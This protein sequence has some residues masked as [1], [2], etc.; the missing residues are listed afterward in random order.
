MTVAMPARPPRDQRLDVVR[1]ILQ[2][3][4][5]ARH[6][7]GS[8]IG[9]WVIHSNWGLSDSSELFLYLSGYTLGSVIA[10]KQARDG[11]AAATWDMLRRT[12][13][14]YR[15]HLAVFMLMAAMLAAVDAWWLPGEVVGRRWEAFWFDPWRAI[16]GM[17]TMVYQPELM[18]ILPM[19]VWSMALL[20]AYAALL[21]RVGDWGL[22]VPIGFYAA[23]QA[24]LLSTPSFGFA[25]GVEFDPIAWQVLFMT[26]AWVGRR[27]LL[28]GTTFDPQ[29]WWARYATIAAIAVLLAGLVLRLAWYGFLPLA[30]PFPEA[31]WITG[32]LELA[33]PRLLHMVALAW[34]VARF[35]PHDRA[36]MHHWSLAWLATVGRFSLEVFCLGLFLAWWA[37]VTLELTGHPMVLDIAVTLVGFALLAGFAQWRDRARNVAP[38]R[39]GGGSGAMAAGAR[40]G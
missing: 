14:L 10:L 22:L 37:T 23:V 34:L 4:I 35:V 11:A 7:G 18:G 5:F 38:V 16:P 26:G 40:P 32:K 1:G 9:G 28:L 3:S 24:G 2:L 6:I 33:A 12:L 15:I 20:P 21:G 29:A 17:L 25:H 30:A 31:D 39:Q 36:W 8:F 19:F 27:V 13:R